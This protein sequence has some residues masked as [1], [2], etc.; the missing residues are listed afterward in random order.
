MPMLQDKKKAMKNEPA[1][2][3]ITGHQPDSPG[4]LLKNTTPSLLTLEQKISNVHENHR[5]ALELISA[6][7]RL[8]QAAC[9]E[10]FG[11]EGDPAGGMEKGASAQVPEGV[12]PRLDDSLHLAVSLSSFITKEQMQLATD[13]KNF[14]VRIG[15]APGMSNKAEG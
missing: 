5:N 2:S 9:E 13:L 10:L 3:K 11:D 4:H 1:Y 7:S 6:S 8:L 14:I 15:V 12:I